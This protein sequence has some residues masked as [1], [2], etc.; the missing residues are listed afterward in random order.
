MTSRS[1]PAIAAW[2]LALCLHSAACSDGAGADSDAGA[3]TAEPTCA[4]RADCEAL[5][6]EHAG[7]VCGALGRCEPCASDG[8]C[9]LK[10]RCDPQTARCTFK[11]GYGD[12]CTFNDECAAG[13]FCVQGLCLPALDVALCA[14][15]RCLMDGQRCNALNGVCEADLGCLEDGDCAEGELCN[16][17]THGCV[18]RCTAES[19]PYLCLPGELCLTDRCSACAV[20]AD[21]APGMT[22]DV[23]ALACVLDDGGVARCSSERDCALDQI[24]DPDLG[25]CVEKKPACTSDE[26][27]ASSERCEI[28]SGKCLPRDCAPDRFE[29][30]DSFEAARAAE[31]TL[32]EGSFEG[33]TICGADV[34]FHAIDLARGDSLTALLDADLL[35]EGRVGIAILDPL[36]RQL[37]AGSLAASGVAVMDGRHAIRVAAT[38]QTSGARVDYGLTLSL[39]TGTPCDF[40]AFEPNDTPGTASRIEAEGSFEGLTICGAEADF[41]LIRA[42]GSAGV[43]LLAEVTAGSA[44]LDVEEIEPGK[45]PHFW[46][47]GA[48]EEHLF[49]LTSPLPR[50]QLTYTLTVRFADDGT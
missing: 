30:N 46:A 26:S 22:C 3:S 29:P 37:G 42:P 9:R 17:P 10:E 39:S 21:C 47:R 15:G 27:C 48:A 2:A 19:A 25:I 5:G 1:L 13:A 45:A 43:R 24:C 40:D 33:L 38:G 4:R 50:A 11:D 32:A 31:R 44:A 14:E 49:L 8:Q 36:E 6:P 12:E 41:F 28:A 23:E 34:D 18:T 7:L 16:L 20:D 35:L